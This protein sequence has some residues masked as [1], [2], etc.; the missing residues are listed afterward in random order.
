MTRLKIQ[1]VPGY[2]EVTISPDILRLLPQDNQAASSMVNE[3][4][5]QV[6]QE[7]DGSDDD[8]LV[9]RPDWQEEVEIG[10]RQRMEGRTV[11]HQEVLEWHKSQLRFRLPARDLGE[12]A[13]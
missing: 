5:S 12:L 4:L 7:R 6:L 9:N 13:I 8:Q 11:S 1:A 3:I 10:R 2:P